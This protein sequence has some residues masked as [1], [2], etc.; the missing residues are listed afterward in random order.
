MSAGLFSIYVYRR[1]NPVVSHILRVILT[2]LRTVSLLL[3]LFIIYE[4]TLHFRYNKTNPPILAIAVDNSASM[5]I[6]DSNGSRQSTLHDILNSDH[7][8]ELGR[9]FQI[10]FYR[11]SNHIEP[12]STTQGD[13]LDFLGDVTNISKSLELIVARHATENLTNIL[14]IS[15]GSYNE[16]GN[17]LRYAEELGVPVH[18]IGIGSSDPV[19]DLAITA[20]DAHPFTYVNQST[21]V[22]VT[23]RNT[24]F[25]K[26]SVPLELRQ[27]DV[28]RET[29]QLPASPA[30][31]T[32]TMSFTPTKVGRAK[33]E[34]NVPQQ[35]GEHLVDNNSRTVYIDVFKEKLQILLI[36]GAVTPDISFI[37]TILQNDR[38]QIKDHIRR[39]KGEFYQQ[40]LS[41]ETLQE[42][43]IFIFLDFP[44]HGMDQSFSQNLSA[45]LNSKKQSVLFIPGIHISL[46]E[47]TKLANFIPLQNAVMLPK[48]RLVRAEPSPLGLNHP[49]LQTNLDPLHSKTVWQQLPPVFAALL[50]QQVPPGTEVLAYARFADQA[51]S[52]LAPLIVARVHGQQK[53]AAIFAHQLWRWDFM[54]SGI[55]RSDKVYTH[56]LQNIMRWLETNRSE[57]LVRVSMDKTH[58]NYGDPI[59][60]SIDVFDENLNPVEKA[61]VK[62]T[63]EKPAQEF[64]SRPQGGGAYSVVLGTPQPGDYTAKVTAEIN[65]HRLGEETVLF[66]VGEYSA[67][68]TDIQAQPAVL[69]ALSRV[70]GGQFLTT[71]SLSQMTSIRGESTTMPLTIEN[72]LWNNKYIL[73]LILLFLTLEWFIR[74]RTGMV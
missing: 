2:L 60:M 71:D 45:S 38:Y 56:L 10:V 40:P 6:T 43:D 20:V 65:G 67:E 1:T 47:V 35:V 18:T 57:S 28:L 13:S 54:M 52:G 29:V 33:V 17:P 58:Y 66:S 73:I 22:Q 51:N 69:Q 26:L 41:F 7:L 11:F 5:T 39:S 30:E 14:L 31:K 16:G 55:N 50:V 49:I 24:G 4:T 61:D 32:V 27:E 46:A 25:D 42:T 44:M 64:P 37:K 68:L 23:I 9:K 36:A 8:V 12:Y 74:K 21:P 62:V 48:E 3:L 34:L 19:I 15:D 72:E 59:S 63:L 53:S 70:T